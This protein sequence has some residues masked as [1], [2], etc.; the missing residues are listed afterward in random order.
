[1]ASGGS[2]QLSSAA[3]ISCSRAESTRLHESLSRSSH[4]TRRVAATTANDP[5]NDKRRR[6]QRMIR[7]PNDED[8]DGHTPRHPPQ[9]S[10]MHAPQPP[11]LQPPHAASLNIEM[12]TR[13]PAFLLRPFLQ[14]GRPIEVDPHGPSSSSDFDSA[15][16]IESA[17]SPQ[18]IHSSHHPTLMPPL[19]TS[20][21]T[22]SGLPHTP[23]VR[24][25][26]V[27]SVWVS[28]C[29]ATHGRCPALRPPLL[30]LVTRRSLLT[31]MSPVFWCCLAV[32]QELSVIATDM[33]DY[34]Q[35]T[36]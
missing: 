12:T 4:A 35:S 25:E 21:R 13:F 6:M 34:Q 28:Q 17:D 11:Q 23:H 24:L 2:A 16:E 1:M 18:P 22:H 30:K 29:A 33:H 19:P 8:G 27:A 10:S 36:E 9:P 14:H 32:Q 26:D 5:H 20:R 3:D 31:L 7:T 15:D